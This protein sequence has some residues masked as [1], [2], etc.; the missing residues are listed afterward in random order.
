M[1]KKYCFLGL[2]LISSLS[3]A[4]ER[5]VKGSG[6]EAAC[7]VD[8]KNHLMLVKAPP[9]S[10]YNWDNANK[11]VKEL[12]LCGFSDWR[13]PT[14]EEQIEL[15]NDVGAYATFAWF[16]THGFDNI[17]TDFYWS[18]DS[19]VKDNHDA[20]GIYMYSSKV[21][22]EPKSNLNYIWPVRKI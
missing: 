2:V 18:S 1:K 8:T 11:Y 5:F 19:Y 3:F 6:S 4:K 14:K 7:V 9:V 22:N 17:Q 10:K 13:L 21:Y 15:Q 20:W 16:N 12:K